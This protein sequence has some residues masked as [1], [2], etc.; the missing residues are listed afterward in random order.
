MYRFVG[1]EFKPSERH[2]NESSQDEIGRDELGREHNYQGFISLLQRTAQTAWESSSFTE[3]KTRFG[4]QAK[5][6]QFDS[7][8]QLSI[9]VTNRMDE[10]IRTY[11]EQSD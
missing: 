10:H 3:D 1:R 2:I 4:P 8:I 6:S 5:A 7:S 9:V 11:G